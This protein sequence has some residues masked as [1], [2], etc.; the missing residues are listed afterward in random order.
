MYVIEYKFK[1]KF[2]IY[3]YLEKCF[4]ISFLIRNEII[5]YI[6]KQFK[7][8]KNDKNYNLLLKERKE[9]KSKNK[10]LTKINSDLKTIRESYNLSKAGLYSYSKKLMKKYKNYISSQMV[11]AICDDC[12]KAFEKVMFS[13]GKEIHFKKYD[14]IMCLKCKDITNGF[15]FKGIYNGKKR[16]STD[17]NTIL[18][19]NNLIFN[20]KIDKNDIYEVNAFRPNDIKYIQITRKQFYNYYHYYIQFVTDGVPPLKT[21]KGIG[22]SGID[23]GVSSVAA[24]CDN[25]CFLEDLNPYSKSYEKKIIKKQ[26]DLNRKLTLNNKDKIKNGKFKK[27]CKLDFSKNAKNDK[28]KI[29]TLQRKKKETDKQY[30]CKIANK[31]IQNCDNIYIEPTNFNA[32]KKRSK[33]TERSDKPSIVKGKTIYKYKK[34]KRFGS[35][36]QNKSPSKFVKILNYKCKYLDIPVIEIDTK[37]FKASQY[38]H[39]KDEYFKKSLSQRWNI[40]D[41]NDKTVVFIQRDLYSAFLIKNSDSTLTRADK[42]KC[43]ENFKRF[44]YHHNKCIDLVRK[45]NNDRLSCFGF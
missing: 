42:N 37:N 23:I 34:K 18:T 4:F 19:P 40:L 13:N 31:I 7:K 29:R 17:Y 10:S 28:K 20:F 36:M 2:N 27:G 38:N 41:L 16:I 32:L 14:D 12:L 1:N 43:N 9:L 35:T 11:Q 26:N 30:K 33:K 44:V 24:V 25:N 45:T 5:K 8:L 39:Q 15:T 21:N 6:K 3:K 22:N